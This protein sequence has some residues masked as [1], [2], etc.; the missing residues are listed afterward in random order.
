MKVTS[1][2]CG[3][4]TNHC[5]TEHGTTH[6]DSTLSSQPASPQ[7]V[8]DIPKCYDLDLLGLDSLPLQ[9]SDFGHPDEL[10]QLV[11]EARSR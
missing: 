4:R 7:P 3:I 2:S 1:R 6:S 5:P 8:L 9:S 11:S 10:Q